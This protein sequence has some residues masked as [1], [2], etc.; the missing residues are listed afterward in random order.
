MRVKPDAAAPAGGAELLARYRAMRTRLNAAPIATK[1]A[2][3]AGWL[4]ELIEFNEL[5]RR[6]FIGPAENA[7]TLAGQRIR[8]VVAAH[9]GIT[10]AEIAGESSARR[11]ARPRQIAMYICARQAGLSLLRIGRI[12][13][14]RDHTTVLY[15]VRSVAQRKDE[16]PALAADISAL[17]DKCRGGAAA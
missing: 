4:A 14:S 7:T 13:G 2:A 12:F 17:I 10:V 3:A 5:L 8:D 11:C 1:P 6:L 16:D 15:A 9:F